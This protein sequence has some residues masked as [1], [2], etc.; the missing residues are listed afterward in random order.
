LSIE[1]LSIQDNTTNDY[2]PALMNVKRIFEEP[3]RQGAEAGNVLTGTMHP[4]ISSKL[5]NNMKFKHSAKD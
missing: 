1:D 2:M 5:G 4:V 3:Q